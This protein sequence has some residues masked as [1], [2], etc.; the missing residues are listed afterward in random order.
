MIIAELMARFKTIVVVTI[1]IFIAFL[2]YAWGRR[3]TGSTSVSHHTV[4]L[5]WKASPG[6]KL[7]YVYRSTVR[8]SQYRKIGS[9]P[10]NSFKDGP[11]PGNTI[12]YYVVTAVDDRGESRHSSEIKV[13]VP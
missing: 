5:T 1:A 6:A 4:T 13:A 7:Y 11:L 3:I 2:I 9:S 12:F 10:T 8:G